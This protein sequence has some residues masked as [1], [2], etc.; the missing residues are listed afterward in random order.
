MFPGAR[1]SLVS[2]VAVALGAA[3]APASASA[4]E[5]TWRALRIDG[6]TPESFQ[7]SVASLQTALPVSRRDD[8]ETALALIWLN[9]TIDADVNNDGRYA[10]DDVRELTAASADL[11][12]DIQRGD[13]VSAIEELDEGGGAYTAADYFEQ[14]DGFGYDEVLVVGGLF[15]GTREEE[16]AVR[17]YRAQ[18][19]CREPSLP[20]RQ[21]WCAAF[22]RSNAATPAP[23]VPVG[24]TLA[25]ATE[26]LKAGDVATAEEAIERLNLNQLTPFE[27]GMAE[28]LLFNVKYRQQLYPEAREHLQAAVDVEIISQAEANA[29]V[30]VIEHFE[31][32]AARPR[33]PGPPTLSAS[34]PPELGVPAEPE[35]ESAPSE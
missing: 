22:F 16:Q 11:L 33:P 20:V 8:F 18:L 17:A 34:T 35:T 21:Q 14:L 2:T 12:A 32:M 4:Q 23:R 10:L 7:A 24:E 9:N 28:A 25:A 27:R 29:I 31:R 5:D 15:G 30:G 13:L 3:L 1:L 19:L 26:A 6:S